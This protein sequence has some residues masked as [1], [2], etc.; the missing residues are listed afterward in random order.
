MADL[1]LCLLDLMVSPLIGPAGNIEF[2]GMWIKKQDT[3]TSHVGTEPGFPVV[4]E[5]ETHLIES[6][7]H[8]AA[9]LKDG[10]TGT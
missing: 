6:V 4:G 3:D 1:G 2:L 8:N 7:L 9:Q 10:K 5:R